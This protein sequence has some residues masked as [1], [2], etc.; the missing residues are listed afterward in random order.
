M[1]KSSKPIPLA[2]SNELLAQIDHAATITARSRSELMRLAIEIGLAD[3]RAISYDIAGTLHRAAK[4]AAAIPAYLQ[5]ST[6]PPTPQ[7]EPPTPIQYPRPTRG[8]KAS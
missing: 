3:L 8:K 1:S 7:P 5:E 2:V 4:A 6:A